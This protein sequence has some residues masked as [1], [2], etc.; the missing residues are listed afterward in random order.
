LP[1]TRTRSRLTLHSQTVAARLDQLEAVCS[2]V[3]QGAHSAGFDD[4]TSY[5]CQLA[6][7]EAA[8]NIVKHGYREPGAG[9][10]RVTTRSRP[11][12]LI[13]DLVDSAP[14]FDP[15][16]AMP[17]DDWEMTNPPV[18]GRGLL[19]IRRVMDDVR[20]ERRGHRNHLRLRKRIQAPSE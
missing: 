9:D 7:C 1:P 18:G 6:V 11:G 2:L 15:T 3:D 14:P 5:A 19:I 20:Y 12:E 13:I 10:I 16:A 4:R 17:D 8:E